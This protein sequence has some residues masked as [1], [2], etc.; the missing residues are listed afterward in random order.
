MLYFQNPQVNAGAINLPGS[1]L[2]GCSLVLAD[3]AKSLGEDPP[4]ESNPPYHLN[5][6]PPTADS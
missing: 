5:L 6:H 4:G 3:A 2:R 1:F